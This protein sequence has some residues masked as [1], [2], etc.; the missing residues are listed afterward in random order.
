[1]TRTRISLLA[2]LISTVAASGLQAAS[3]GSPP[4]DIVYARPGQLVDAGDFG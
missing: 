3:G 2:V 4:A 1:M